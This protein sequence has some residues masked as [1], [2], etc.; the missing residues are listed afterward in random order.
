M[1]ARILLVDDDQEQREAL[2]GVLEPRGY[3]AMAACD[4]HEAL[5][6]LDRRPADVVVSDLD[7]PGMDVTDFFNKVREAHPHTC[8]I[9][10]T[11]QGAIESAVESIRKGVYTYIT[12]PVSGDELLHHV[13]LA[14]QNRRL[15]RENAAL[16]Q[17]V[18]TARVTREII[19][20]SKEMQALMEEVEMAAGS[21]ATVLIRGESGTGKRLIAE[22]IHARSS[23]HEGPFVKVSC[24]AVPE[25][26]LEDELFGH[27][28]GAFTT[29]PNRRRGEFEMAHTGTIFLDEIGETP[30][31]LQAKILRVLQEREFERI[32]G[33]Q[34]IN[35]DVRLIAATNRN[36]EQ[37]VG[38]RKF[39]ED[40]YYRINVVPL[41]VPPLRKRRGDILL[42]ANH[43]LERYAARNKRKFKGISR[44]AQSA[45]L[46]Y[47]WP[48][49]VRE[50]E[51]AVERA[52]V[53]SRSK[54]IEEKDLLPSL[55]GVPFNKDEMFDM[56][57]D[58]Q[59]PLKTIEKELVMRSLKRADGNRTKAAKM[60]GLSRRTLQY[61]LGK[62]NI[63]EPS[64]RNRKNRQNR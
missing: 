64:S 5:S 27:E 45:L 1:K 21:D 46:N 30:P 43:F 49:N 53:M 26:L 51:N 38:E 8:F 9:I 17:E 62:Y 12:R 19:C 52:V 33:S 61:R 41:T 14:L 60:L 59:V 18:K 37:M 13:H 44:K 15:E 29:A 42:L 2:R 25:S 35:V 24:A 56:L 23:R 63:L 3:E 28:K 20:S 7:T 58:E 55:K 48:G 39:R 32:G 6:L 50:L 36:L 22:A 31:A 47:S 4:W 34:A 10:M 54:Y 11:E 57:L 40:L 16:R